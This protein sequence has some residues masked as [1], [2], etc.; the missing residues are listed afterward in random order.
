MLA[1]LQISAGIN[2]VAVKTLDEAAETEITLIVNSTSVG[3]WPN[4]DESP[5]FEG[6]PFPKGVTVYDMVY[7]PQMTR[8]MGQAEAN[9]GQAISGLG[10]LV[11]QG[12]A[13][14]KIWTGQDAPVDVM[15]TAAQTVLQS[16]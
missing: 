4:V 8:F 5:W 14:F 7:R 15:Y 9:G 10:M 16:S 3:M 1:D 12:A 13:A 6:V 2:N 11:R